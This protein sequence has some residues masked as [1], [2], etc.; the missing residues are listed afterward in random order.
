VGRTVGML[1]TSGC[2]ADMV[3]VVSSWKE[4][5]DM[6][7]VDKACLG[8]PQDG[9]SVRA[10][11]HLHVPGS[12]RTDLRPSHRAT[13]QSPAP[14]QEWCPALFAPCAPTAC[15]SCLSSPFRF[16][17]AILQLRPLLGSGAICPFP[18][19]ALTSPARAAHPSVRHVLSP[20][21]ATIFTRGHSLGQPSPSPWDPRFETDKLAT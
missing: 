4:E 16:R 20:I 11:G 6:T 13:Q 7:K 8:K 21:M 15:V 19:L 18:C 14:P 2:M 1:I 3:F 17:T 9:E 10:R 12:T 5:Q